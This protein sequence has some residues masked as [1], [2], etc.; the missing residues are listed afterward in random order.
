MA[1]M[2]H[3]SIS[4]LGDNAL[5]ISFGNCLEVATNERVLQ[6]FH[7]LKNFAPFIRDVVPAYASLAVYYDVHSL[8]RKDI[9][10]FERVKELLLPLLNEGKEDSRSPAR[11]VI[12]PVC[13]AKN[14]ALDLEELAAQKGL[15][16]EEIIQLH[17]AIT[18][19]VYTI[20]FLPGFPYMGT[21]DE[22]I[23]APRKSSPRTS[24]PA[25]S[26]GIAGAQTGIYPLSS[27]GGWNIIG[28]TPVK[29]FDKDRHHPVL[30]QPG[31]WVQFIS[32][33]EDEFED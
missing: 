4:P 26:V 24:I 6:L 9:S 30:L 17:T 5:L 12:I 20:G 10:A 16:P 14:Y 2:Q 1:Y 19:R 23:A 7:R 32:I 22:R 8:H 3:F 13:Y 11:E 21:V 33:T 29:L 18:Y 27:P 28:R 25:G 15:T 31:D